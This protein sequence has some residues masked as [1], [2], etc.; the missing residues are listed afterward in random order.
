[1]KGCCCLADEESIPTR[2][3]NQWRG[4]LNEHEQMLKKWQKAWVGLCMRA[5]M[6]VCMHVSVSS[7]RRLTINLYISKGR[8]L[9]KPLKGLEIDSNQ[10]KARCSLYKKPFAS[11][12]NFVWGFYVTVPSFV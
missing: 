7:V 8:V 1:M 10:R 3:L 6:C 12:K 5:C 11:F 4:A 9:F 2:D